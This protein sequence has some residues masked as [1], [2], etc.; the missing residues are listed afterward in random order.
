MTSTGE[1]PGGALSG[2]VGSV[3]RESVRGADTS[4]P[5]FSSDYTQHPSVK[6]LP[7]DPSFTQPVASGHH[8]ARTVDIDSG[9]H[10][11]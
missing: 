1:Q 6:G 7:E 10:R 5:G 3:P 9:G 4:P 8:P 2:R 11:I